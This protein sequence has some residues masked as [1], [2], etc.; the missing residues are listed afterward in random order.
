MLDR[1]KSEGIRYLGLWGLKIVGVLAALYVWIEILTRIINMFLVKFS[2]PIHA[3]TNWET[4]L[5]YLLTL[6][7]VSL[8]IGVYIAYQRLAFYQDDYIE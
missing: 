8:L 2:I 7:P 4:F 1:S 3:F 6:S 5:L